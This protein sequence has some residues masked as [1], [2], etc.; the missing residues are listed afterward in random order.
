M[1]LHRCSP[2]SNAYAGAG[3]TG[4][5]APEVKAATRKRP[6]LRSATIGQTSVHRAVVGSLD[7]LLSAVEG[8]ATAAASRGGASFH[9]HLFSQLD[10]YNLAGWNKIFCDV[11]ASSDEFSAHNTEQALVIRVEHT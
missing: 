8:S 7:N 6:R 4:D 5:A 10:R 11:H 9:Q 1:V 2:T 3:G